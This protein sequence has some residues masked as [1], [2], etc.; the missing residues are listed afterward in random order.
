MYKWYLPRSAVISVLPAETTED[1]V[2]S[3]KII[4]NAIV[5]VQI[6]Y[7]SCINFIVVDFIFR[8]NYVTL[9]TIHKII[10]SALNLTFNS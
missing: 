6:C 3:I 1:F 7:S 9:I 4:Q 2:V 10:F 5:S 8:F